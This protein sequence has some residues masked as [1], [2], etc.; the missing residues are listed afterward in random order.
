MHSD[1][2][3]FWWLWHGIDGPQGV[4]AMPGFADTLSAEE[5]WNVIDYVRVRNAGSQHQRTGRWSPTLLAPDLPI[6]CGDG[7]RSSLAELRGHPV[8]LVIGGAPM[9]EE[10]AMAVVVTDDPAISPSA[11][12]CVA[13]GAAARAYALAAGVFGAEADG[14][15]FLVDQDG[16]LRAM[17]KPASQDGWNNPAQLAA[18]LWLLAAAPVTGDRSLCHAQE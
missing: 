11:G 9:P 12:R 5:I 3:L 8:R 4:R 2:E 16:W 13:G 7:R 17:Q 18:A 14:M 6:A 1:G 10:A 15:Q